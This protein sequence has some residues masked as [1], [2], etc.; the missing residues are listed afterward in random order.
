MVKPLVLVDSTEMVLLMVS[1]QRIWNGVRAAAPAP[2]AA[3]SAAATAHARKIAARIALSQ[4]PVAGAQLVEPESADHGFHVRHLP[5][6]HPLQQFV[7]G[8]REQFQ[9]FAFVQ[10]LR[11]GRQAARQVDVE[12]F[13]GVRNR[14]VDGADELPV[15]GRVA[16]FLEQLALGAVER[17][18]IG[19]DFPGR[20]LD[21]G[22][23][24]RVAELCDVIALDFE[25]MAIVGQF[26]VDAGFGQEGFGD[27]H[28][29][30]H[31]AG[32][33]EDQEQA[34]RDCVELPGLREAGADIGFQ[35][36]ADGAHDKVQRDHFQQPDHQ[37]L[38]LPGPAWQRRHPSGS[39]RGFHRRLADRQQR[40]WQHAEGQDGHAVQAQ[41]QL[42][43]ARRVERG[44]IGRLV[45]PH[46][47][48]DAQVVERA[49][50]REHHRHDRQPDLARAQHGAQHR[51]LGG[52]A[53]QR[54]HA[55]HR[56]HHDGHHQRKP[57]AAFAQ[58]LEVGD[59]V[60]VETGARQQHQ[61]AEGAHSGQHIGDHVEHRRAVCTDH[62]AAIDRGA[63]ARQQAQQ[64][65]ADLR[66]GRVG[67]HAFQVGLGNCGQVTDDQRHHG[68][69]HQHLLPVD[70][71]RQQAFHQQAD[72][73]G[74]GGDFRCAAQQ[75]G[76][77]RWRAFIDVR[78]PHVERHGAQ[79]ER[80]AGHQEHDAE[81]Q[82]RRLD[83]AGSY[84]G[85]NLR[86]FQGAGGAVQHRHA[87]EQEARCQ[88]AQDEVLHRRF[89]R[90][91]VIATQCNQRVQAQRHQF[92]AQVHGEEVRTGDHHH[93]AQ[94]G[95]QRQD[96]ELAAQVAAHHAA[97]GGVLAR[98]DQRQGH[99]QVRKQLE[100]V[101]HRVG[102]VHAVEGVDGGAGVEV[103]ERDR[104]AD[105]QQHQRQHVGNRRLHGVGEW[106]WVQAHIQHGDGQDAQH[107]EF[108]AVHV[109]QR[110]HVVVG[111]FAEDHALGH[112][113]RVRRAE[114]QC[115]GGQQ[116][117]PEVV[118]HG[119]QDH[120]ELA[121]E[122]GGRW[123]AAVG[124]RE[125]HEQRREL[126]HLVDDAAVVGDLARV[127]LVVQHADTQEHR[128]GDEAVRDHLHDGALH[129]DGVEDEEAQ[130][131]KAHVCDRRIRDQFFHVLLDQR[132]QA[133][134][135]HGD[136]RQRD[137]HAR[138]VVRGVRR[139]GQRE[140]QEAVG[141]Q[142]QHDGGQH[143]GAAGRRFHVDVRQPG[144]DRE[145]RHFHGKRH[146]EGDEQED[147]L[148]HRQHGHVPLQ[149]VE[150]ARLTVQVDDGDQRQQRTEERV[151]EELERRVHAVL[152]APH[153]DDDVHRDQ[154]RFE[155]EV[156]QQAVHGA[157]HADHQAGQ[158]QERAHV[159][160][161]ARLDHLPRRD[162]H[163]HRDEGR[164]R[165]EP[166]RQAVDA[167][168]VVD[169][170]RVDPLAALD[171]L[172][173]VGGIIEIGN[174]RNGRHKADDGADQRA[175]TYQAGVG[176]A[177][178]RQ[179]QGAERDRE[180]DR[181]AQEVDQEP[182]DAQD[183]HERVVV[184]VTSLAQ[185]RQLREPVHDLGAA[186]DQQAVDQ[187]LVADIPQAV[188][189]HAG[190]AGK[191]H[192]VELVHVV[193]VVQQRVDGFELGKEPGRHARVD[194][195]AVVRRGYTGNGQPQRQSR[196]RVDRH[197][198]GTVEFFIQ[199]FHR[200]VVFTDEDHVLEEVAVQ[201]RA[202]GDITDQ[203]RRD[204]QH[205]QR[206]PDHER[207]FMR[208]LARFQAVVAVVVF[209]FLVVGVGIMT[210]IVVGAV[211]GSRCVV[212]MRVMTVGMGL[213]ETLFT[214]EHQKIH[215]ERVERGH[216]HTGQHGEVGETGAPDMGFVH[217][218]DDRILRV[219]TR[220]ERRADQCQ[221]T[222]QR[223]DP[224]DRH[225][226]A[227]AAHVADVLV[228]VHAD[229]DRTGAEEQQC[230]EECVGHQ[231]EH[232]Y[233]VGRA[234]QSHG[235]VAE[236]RQRR[237]SDHALDV[238]LDNAQEAH[239][240]R[241]DR[242]DDQDERQRGVRQLEQRRHA[243]H[244]E[245]A[246]GH[247][248][249]GVDQGRDR[250]RTFH[251]VRQ[252]HVQR[253]LGR[254]THGADEQ[255]D[256]CHGQQCPVGA[257]QREQRQRFAL[258]KHFLVVHGA[259]VGQQQADA[260]DEAEVAH[261][262]DQE[263]LHV[264]DD[265]GRTLVPET[266]Q[267]VRDQAHRFPAEEQL[268]EVVGHDQHQ[269]REREQRDVR[270]EAVIAFVFRHVA[271]GVD[272]HHQRHER[273]HAHHHRR[274]RVDLE[275]DFEVDAGHRHPVVDG[276]V[277]GSAV[278]HVVERHRRQDEGNQY[279]QDGRRV[280]RFAS[281]D[282]AEEFGS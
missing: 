155:E 242:T 244:H 96:V 140:T 88:G 106:R 105:R 262:V 93:L 61:H 161:H 77:C 231:V 189:E 73:H 116:A 59:V 48:H 234:T 238:V 14:I 157:E 186:V 86:D 89:G 200:L 237:V 76:H 184:D 98:V 206:E 19:V 110:G 53:H 196:Q 233:R 192:F 245:D 69:D 226:F 203:D 169:V 207:R 71:H 172:H 165:H 216:E 44:A 228:V 257:W 208:L 273:H 47:F 143:G 160:G 162:H 129:A 282:I 182:Q 241:G 66:D 22:L 239:E 258:G 166:Q 97:L 78:Y 205:H 24:V 240:Q 84:G 210:M 43:V 45:E 263:R 198:H 277:I 11:A 92:H 246:G 23:V 177:A 252:P 204:R 132:D 222:Q 75:Q 261:A 17:I 38:A 120:H 115:R 128:A 149:N 95:K 191:H 280:G 6:A 213:A 212:G 127:G 150:G 281:H 272:V 248:R 278:E 266:D 118:L 2:A 63:H 223:R 265:R 195:V 174:E 12:V 259:G 131:H 229:D 187:G 173:A 148:F 139:D 179:D 134:V 152:A 136:Q 185:A 51:E 26:A 60:G 220:E 214:V 176:I 163:D 49:D 79:F 253:E 225:V 124:H 7:D 181:Q 82:D 72:A 109:D 145:H 58:A 35:R 193:L 36:K 74:K 123:Q 269:H 274:Q 178:Q 46:G 114:D 50:Q 156:E 27:I 28:W 39:Q 10:L 29:L 68:Q 100:Q 8:G 65:E 18:F 111:H 268:Q 4:L 37:R 33:A 256:A 102:H 87:V 171:E 108:A 159:L 133:D 215:A 260:E 142:F 209:F 122:T 218:F 211:G 130:R 32:E 64:H 83:G 183:H 90:L 125:E 52:K 254:F 276:A 264:G 121:D 99:G 104:R 144:V 62:A 16:G 147:L 21:E 13:V 135:D 201:H 154:G 146:E 235:H 56:E 9:E 40:A 20:E 247:H 219:E 271:D 30:L 251:R 1:S 80:Q 255:A 270:E 113:Q 227:Q 81:D 57:A 25:E 103:T 85:G 101:R 168:C 180:P 54:R 167:Q 42:H 137:H 202:D 55:G 15:G 224:G 230:L 117:D 70:R 194:H 107:E 243:R 41:D 164:E 153:A 279:A 141:A 158:D 31:E 190:A 197:G 5:F 250:G 175:D 217:G 34:G 199:D 232:G 119:A 91:V 188:T 94:R 138:Q 151:Q 267:E 236:L 3:A 67:Q 275:A 170:E 221:R 249:C 126:R 112:P